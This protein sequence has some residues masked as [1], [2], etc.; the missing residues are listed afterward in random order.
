MRAV[1]IS[2]RRRR[3]RQATL[4]Q[5]SPRVSESPKV[6]QSRNS[7]LT[8]LTF[9]PQLV[10]MI[11]GE[12]YY[13]PPLG[14]ARFLALAACTSDRAGD[15]TYSACAQWCKAESK[16]Y[17]C[18]FCK[19]DF[20]DFCPHRGVLPVA[21]RRPAHVVC[22]EPVSDSMVRLTACGN[23]LLQ[24]DTKR[25][26]VLAGIN[27]FLEWM[28]HIHPDYSTEPHAGVGLSGDIRLLRQHLPSANL[29][30][31]VGV[32]WKDSLPEK[33]SV[34]GLEC[35]TDDVST[36]FLHPRCLDAMDSFVR[37]ATSAGLWVILAARAKYA[38]GWG[39][40]AVP[41]AF[42][43]AGVREQFLQMWAFLSRRYRG[44]DR[45]AGYEIMSEPRTKVVPQK[46]VME[47]MQ[48][49]CDVVHR[50]DPN[51]LCV[52]GPAPYY[53]AWNFDEG[54]LLNRP[55]VLYTLDFFVPESF[56]MS[57]SS[58]SNASFPGLYECRDVFDTWWDQYCTEPTAAVCVDESWIA[59]TMR[60]VPARMRT[61][62]AVPVY[63]NQ[64][65]VKGEVL[66]SRGRLA[67]A[68][69]LLRE[70]MRSNISSSY[71][72][73]RAQRK[74]GRS[75][76]QP[77]WGFELL[78]HNGVDVG[79]DE[80]MLA[81]LEEGFANRL[82]P[83]QH[84]VGCGVAPGPIRDIRPAATAGRIAEPAGCHGWC[85]DGSRE[86]AVAVCRS[87]KCQPCTF[88]ASL[89]AAGRADEWQHA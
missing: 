34:D 22:P 29:V 73:W 30:R 71:W 54:V 1:H 45:I 38:A 9:V 37:E 80:A 46:E 33:A 8:H 12:L 41:D 78:R 14:T 75:M 58:K 26:V 65:G 86:D 67:Y 50:A 83:A 5:N 27:F 68:S 10:L 52:V 47:L 19:C 28:L 55:N 35:S 40:P 84:D 6:T 3:L 44:Y 24:T 57:D 69:A 66:A 18:S 7:L 60:D 87:S 11:E 51:A 88:C 39:Y 42:H 23:E 4:P 16:A 74:E 79:F 56:V 64:W 2:L 89:K 17:H 61:E 82:P 59:S 62:H 77:V 70:M 63:V 36:G 21:P 76:D 13:M 72:I 81:L 53:K 20:C 32:L 15:S 31:F 85:V 48:A 49:G 43:D 25:P